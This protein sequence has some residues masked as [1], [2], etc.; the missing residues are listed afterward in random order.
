MRSILER[1]D[2]EISETVGQLDSEII[3]ADLEA[4]FP[5]TIRVAGPYG[6][7]HFVNIVGHDHLKN[8]GTRRLYVVVHDPMHGYY[9]GSANSLGYAIRLLDLRGG[10]LQNYPATW[11]H[12]YRYFP[13]DYDD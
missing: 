11:T 8:H 9:Q 10:R 1:Y 2:Y 7:G 12:S 6:N 4:G 3:V 5:V 13:K